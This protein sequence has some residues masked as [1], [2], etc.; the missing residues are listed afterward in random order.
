MKVLVQRVRSAAVRIDDEIVGAID[1]GLLVFL[2]VEKEDTEALATWYARRVVSLKLFPGPEGPLWGRTVIEVDGELLVVSQFT[3]A[4]RTRKGRRPSFDGAAE[5]ELAI[6]LYEHFV[7][8]LREQGARVEQGRF[9]A[10][11]AVQLVND[12]PVTFL[13]DGPAA[14]TL[15]GG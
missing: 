4:A 8:T 7:A 2:G 6:P 1:H 9:G 11:M 5:P 3:L 15:S 13:L 12:G 14:R 10:R